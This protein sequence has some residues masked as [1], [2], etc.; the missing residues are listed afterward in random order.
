MMVTM[1]TM[2]TMM[3]NKGVGIDHGTTDHDSGGETPV[4]TAVAVTANAHHR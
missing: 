3:T 1:M 2:M 4:Y